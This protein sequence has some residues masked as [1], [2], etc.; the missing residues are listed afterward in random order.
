MKAIYVLSHNA[1]AVLNEKGQ[2][3]IVVGKGIGF[4][5]GKGDRINPKLIQGVFIEDN[6]YQEK[7]KHA[8]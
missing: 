5:K 8:N 7:L 4:K 2:T 3:C 1:V 6:H